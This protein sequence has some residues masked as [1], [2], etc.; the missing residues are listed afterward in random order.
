[1]VTAQVTLTMVLLTGAG[2]FGRTLRN[3]QNIDPGFSAEGVLLVDL[4]DRR[5]PVPTGLVHEIEHL[6][7]V[8]SASISTHTPLNGWVWGE[9]AVPAG[10]VIPERDNAY[11]IGAGPRFFQT[12]R[13]H[14]LSGREFT[15]RDSAASPSVAVVNEAFA[16]RHFPNLNP[17]GQ[18]L[19]ANVRGHRRDLEIVGVASN[20][21]AAGLR[22]A[23]PPTVYVVYAQLTG[24][25]P[26]T[27]AVRA[28]GPL[29]RVAS[30]LQQTL[31]SILPGELI[32]VHSLSAQVQAT[33]VQ[34]RMM[35]T[36]AA[37]FGLLAL[38]LACVGVYG[39]LAYSVVQRTRE[40]GIRMALGA[41]AT[42]VVRLVLH[43]ATRL[44][45]IGIVIGLPVAWIASRWV[46]S[47]LFG[48]TATDPSTIGG[49][50]LLL[51]AASQIAAYLPA[52]RASR[53]DPLTAL[54]H[55]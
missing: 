36:L 40:I 42:R 5:I 30:A 34:E 14:L 32:E 17:V 49:V 37:G 2:L 45:L 19:S 15:D 10:Q 39:L 43:G 27:L 16:K 53:L 4:D 35:A 25:L 44:V 8:T 7:G 11:F 3:L 52:R 6:P 22:A 51:T 41:Q 1:L 24:D 38:T 18:H 9:P 46:E 33:I 28:T 55:E 48:L 47:L 21:N 31:Q 13:I 50:V 54:R 20:T 26:T 12:M 23:P 29:G